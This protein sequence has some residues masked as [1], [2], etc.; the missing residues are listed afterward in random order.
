MKGIPL[1]RKLLMWR[2]EV[3]FIHDDMLGEGISVDTKM[4]ENLDNVINDL[5]S[6]MQRVTQLLNQ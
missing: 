2:Q 6:I 1:H 3:Q 5:D 4:I